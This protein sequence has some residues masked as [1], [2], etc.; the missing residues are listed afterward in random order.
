[1]R[2]KMP[3]FLTHDNAALFE[4]HCCC[5]REF[6]SPRLCHA[7]HGW[8][9]ARQ[10]QL[11][12]RNPAPF[13]TATERVVP[14]PFFVNTASFPELS[15]ALRSAFQGAPSVHPHLVGHYWTRAKGPLGAPP[16]DCI[17]RYLKPASEP[18]SQNPVSVAERSALRKGSL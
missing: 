11:R 18:H 15:V 12:G 6:L 9:G 3:P 7:H 1:M 17:F 10:A 2:N 14:I 16:G 4:C 13:S 8:L 5:Q